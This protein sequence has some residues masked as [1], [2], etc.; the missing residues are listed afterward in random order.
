[1]N[2]CHLFL[3]GFMS[4]AMLMSPYSMHVCADISSKKSEAIMENFKYQ[5]EHFSICSSED[6]KEEVLE[7]IP[8][9]EEKYRIVA[10]HLKNELTDL[11]EVKVYSNLDEFHKVIGWISAPDWVRGRA[12]DGV[13]EVVLEDYETSS[14]A[15]ELIIHE[16]T[17]IITQ[18]M[19]LDWKYIP[20]VLWE[21]I[22][23]YEAGQS[24][25]KNNLHTLKEIPSIEELFSL[26]QNKNLYPLAYSFVE[27][28]I[29]N[30]GYE[31][32]IEILN[33][34]YKDNEF[35]FFFLQN[36]YSTW[37]ALLRA[38]IDLF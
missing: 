10:S 6:K 22:A 8:K 33:I 37:A 14:R 28:L 25:L 20:P 3:S 31:K 21:G 30:F 26:R 27:F 19:N 35:D 16:T 7:I 38:E 15:I 32:I 17:H 4:F 23:T 18:N 12:K 34:N 1:M 29:Q 36:E 2:A 24:N 11:V 5:S 9:L 13:I